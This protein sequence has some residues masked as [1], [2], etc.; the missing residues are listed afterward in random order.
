LT[1]G[2]DETTVAND[3]ATSPPSSAGI[4]NFELSCVNGA[5][6]TTYA[7]TALVVTAPP[8]QSVDGGQVVK[9]DGGGGSFSWPTLAVLALATGLAALHRRRS[10]FRFN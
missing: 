7:Y 5:G 2:N 9:E 6:V 4:G 8:A 10:F 1:C 3:S